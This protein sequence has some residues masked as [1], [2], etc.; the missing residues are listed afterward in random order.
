MKKIIVLTGIF[1]FLVCIKISAQ[2]IEIPFKNLKIL[3]GSTHAHSIFSYSHGKHLKRDN[4]FEK[5]NEEMLIDS[6][7]LSRPNNK[8]LK[9]NW[10][11][12]QGLP[13][14]HYEEAKKAK[15]DFYFVTD[16]SME[17]PF[18]PNSSNS[19]AWA[20]ARKQAENASSKDFTAFMGVEHSENDSSNGR[21]H[22]NVIGSS[23]YINA[24]RPEIDI[25]YFYNWL[26]ENPKNLKTGNP[27]VVT[28]N[29]PDK[30]QYNNW[31]YRDEEITKIITLLEIINNRKSK[32][33]GFINALDKGWKVSPVA[34]LDNHNFTDI[35]KAQART[36]VLVE[37][38]T[39][40]DILT[41][42]RKRRTYA[43]FDKNLECRYS[44]NDSIMGSNIPESDTY[45]LK[46]FINDPDTNEESDKITKIDIITGKGKI[47]KSINTKDLKH[48]NYLNISVKNQEL[49]NYL[50]IQIWDNS[51]TI[52]SEIHEPVAWLAPV[53]IS[54]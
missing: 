23:A 29:H 37:N 18:F 20:I 16:H 15:F 51:K 53:W 10:N 35:S 43:S 22:F 46:N 44:V 30:K 19:A 54:K 3:N 8:K 5:G 14:K 4:E 7:F 25:P 9:E 42:M 11:S 21:G 50:F 34:G 31:A 28:F 12:F 1:T 6:L 24:I 32:Y 40:K 17:V 2:N 13:E 26:K 41:A 47:I 52:D 33:E 45:N 39:P 49:E 36:F 38:N 27:V 48:K